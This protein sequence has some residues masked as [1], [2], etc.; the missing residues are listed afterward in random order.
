LR[1]SGTSGA[2]YISYGAIRNKVTRARTETT[3]SDETS[4]ISFA[5][6]TCDTTQ[7]TRCS[8]VGAASR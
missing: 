2:A 1:T 6:N 8:G 5:A 7:T 4:S 3:V